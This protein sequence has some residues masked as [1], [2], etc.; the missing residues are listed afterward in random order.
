LRQP[1]DPLV[2][3]YAGE[4]VDQPD[5]WDNYVAPAGAPAWSTAQF[6]ALQRLRQVAHYWID[7]RQIPNGEFGGKPDDDVETLRWWPTLMFSGDR[8]GDGGVWPAGRGRS[9]SAGGC[10]AAIRASPA[11]SSTRRNSS[12]TRCR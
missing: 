7:E 5:P 3:M 9:G 10:I 11:T 12:P 4:D 1:Q 2:A 6:E 8:Q